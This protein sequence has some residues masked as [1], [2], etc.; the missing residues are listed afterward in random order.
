MNRAQRL[1]LVSLPINLSLTFATVSAA[2]SIWDALPPVNSAVT[3]P[4]GRSASPSTDPNAEILSAA[5]PTSISIPPSTAAASVDVSLASVGA[6][7]QG[8]GSSYGPSISADGSSIAFFSYS[9]NLVSGDSNGTYD[10]FVKNLMTGA[11]RLVSDGPNGPAN[12]PSY[13][14]SISRDGRKVAFFSYGSN[15]IDGDAND[16]YDV[17]VKDVETRV[18]T[19]A[20][21]G[22]S[23]QGNRQSFEPS[24][25]DDGNKVAFFSYANNLVP[26]D[27]NGYGDVFVK[28][29]L[30]GTITLVSASATAQGNGNSYGSSLSENGAKAAFTSEA[31]NL[32]PGDTNRAA[33]VFV[34][35]LET[36]ALAMVSIGTNGPG[37]KA[38]QTGMRSLSA[39][40]NK[41]VF[42]SDATN[43]VPDDNNDASDVFVK[44]LV[45]EVVTLVSIG[46]AGQGNGNSYKASISADGTK[47]AFTSDASNLVAGDT[48]ATG[49]VFIKDL[50]T[51]NITLVSTGRDGPSNR[52]SDEA[53]L[54]ANGNKV[55][56]ESRAT[57][58]I[59]GDLN[60][61]TD[62]FVATMP[63]VV[64]C[65]ILA[66]KEFG[67]NPSA[68]GYLNNVEYP[69][70]V[71]DVNGDKKA[72]II[73]FANHATR[74][75]LG[76]SRGTF[77]EWL[78]ALRNFHIFAGWV[79]NDLH[80]RKAG[81]VNGD[82]RADI[83][84]F[85]KEGTYTALGTVTGTF[86]PAQL[87]L[88]DFHANT[89]V[90]SSNL[91]NPRELGHVNRDKYI[92]IVGFKDDGVYVALGTSAG[93]FEPARLALRDFGINDGWINADLYPRR[94][95]DVN[96]DGYVDIVGFK[97]DGVY[98]ALGTAQ[99]TFEP[100]RLVLSEFATNTT[101]GGWTGN[102][103]YPREL[104]DMNGD[105]RTDIIGFAEGGVYVA[106]GTSTGTFEPMRLVLPHFGIKAGGWLNTYLYPR[107]VADVDG[108]G[109]LD[110]IGF[111]DDGVY[112]ALQTASGGFCDGAV[113]GR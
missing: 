3:E 16:A 19:L 105:G 66:T 60:G 11:L 50:T 25:S 36:G 2:E 21:A 71:G 78:Y 64:E 93:T 10:V 89:G 57:N 76:T 53:S 58:L 102:T 24:I 77:D 75:G 86:E 44:D 29:L 91:S 18:L 48:N 9:S 90:W 97:S 41:V 5:T 72:D 40:G 81:D 101:A 47:V 59:L 12:R 68:H 35:N 112:V 98:V 30:A 1:A 113:Q 104:G 88:N 55:A 74:V 37:N 85:N 84:G 62:V 34:K 80:P 31:S 14:P 42:T 23:G 94:V 54:S 22:A 13:A 73:G 96:G 8:D 51:G 83:V 27:V 63:A 7:G 108:D 56:F 17:F 92:D 26:G 46:R 28:D 100:A 111:K 39:D 15:L 107:M 32:V 38:S 70:I 95:G 49:D 43:L 6:Y 103:L 67:F 79:S 20:S 87:A 4:T 45:T 69:R 109:R 99:G 82:G 33:D 110:I 65:P 106:L 61:S 52:R